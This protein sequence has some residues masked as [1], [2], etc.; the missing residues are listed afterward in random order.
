M[1]RVRRLYSDVA[2]SN[3]Q[4]LDEFYQYYTTKKDLRPLIYRPRNATVLRSMDLKDPETNKPVQPRDPVRPLG[5]GVLNGYIES[6]QGGSTELLDWVHQWCGVSLRK[7]TLFRY[8]SG[9]HLQTMLF[10]SLFRIGHYSH[11]LGVLHSYQPR[12]VAA[13]NNRAY[14]VEEY[15]NTVVACSLLRNSAQELVNPDIA[16][17]KLKV[18]WN[19]TTTRDIKTGLTWPL[20]QAYARQQGIDPTKI[21]LA[22]LEK[23]DVVIQLPEPAEDVEAYISRNKNLYY[24]ARVLASYSEACPQEVNSFIDQYKKSLST[25]AKQDDYESSI[26]SMKALLV[27]EEPKEEPKEEAEQEQEK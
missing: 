6:I 23:T 19:K 25:V 24:I 10:S 21:T 4:L 7:K 1:L 12:I 5:K 3:K 27:K 22:G 20:V 17:K 15:F 26:E 11:T 9:S 8:L 13:G 18:N 16:L 14:N 2:K